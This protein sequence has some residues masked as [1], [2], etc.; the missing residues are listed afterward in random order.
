MSDA[1]AHIALA[2][3]ARDAGDFYAAAIQQRRAIALLRGD[4]WLALGRA[5]RHLAEILLAGG[6]VQEASCV[7]TELLALYGARSDVPPLERA[8]ALR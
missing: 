2:Q 6:E 5:I 4:D 7:V 3:R 1:A 8:D